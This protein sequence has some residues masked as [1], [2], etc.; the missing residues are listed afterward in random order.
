MSQPPNRNPPFKF[1]GFRSPNYTMVP[2]ELF[3]ELLPELTGAELKVLLYIIRRTFG[4]KKD[5]DAISLSQM[6]RGITTRDGQVL[7][8]G[9]GLSKPTLLQALR[10]LKALNIIEADRSASLDRGDEP[11]VYRLNFTESVTE[12]KTRPP[13]VKKFDHGGGEETLPGGRAKNLTTQETVLQETDIQDSNIRMVRP[14]EKVPDISEIPHT[15]TQRPPTRSVRAGQGEDQ[16]PDAT[17]AAMPSTTARRQTARIRPPTPLQ[18]A[19]TAS[20]DQ[21][22]NAGFASAGEL[23]KQRRRRGHRDYGED[24]QVILEYIADF[25]REFSDQAPLQ[26]STTRALNL[27]EQ[28]GL[29]RDAFIGLMYEARSITKERSA[30]IGRAG[31][32]SLRPPAAKRKMAYFFACLEDRLG[33]R[34]EEEG[35]E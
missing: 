18:G 13:V 29:S 1:R 3:D 11:T 32:G 7:D 6:L 9:V 27:F 22:T 28:S 25:A 24:R 17:A 4:F 33:L 15:R 30:S 34:E 26:S 20:A 19:S 10:S 16:Q 5:E 31:D 14:T 23:L 21:Q 12:Q 35:A 8:R 2:D